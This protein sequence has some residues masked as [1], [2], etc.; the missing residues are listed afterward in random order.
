LLS[1]SFLLTLASNLNA[2]ETAFRYKLYLAGQFLNSAA[3]EETG[4]V[5][6]GLDAAL[7][8]T[9]LDIPAEYSGYKVIGIGASAFLN[10]NLS[11]VVLPDTLISIGSRAFKDNLL[12]EILIP[13]KV[14][15]IG[16]A[17]FAG[18]VLEKAVLG[19]AVV[20]I[21]NDAF[22]R[23]KLAS[24]TLGKSLEVIGYRAFESNYRIASLE[25]PETLVE[26]R[27]GAFNG[28]A[29]EEL[30]IPSSVSVIEENAF[31]YNKLR[32]ITIPASVTTLGEGAFSANSDLNLASFLGDRPSIASDSIFAEGDLQQISYCAGKD[33]WPGSE[34]DGI[35]PSAD[36]DGDGISDSS[37]AFP[38][39]AS[40]SV[41]TDGDD[42]GNNA[43]TDDDNDGVPDVAGWS[44][45]GFDIYGREVGSRI[46]HSV[47][48]SNDG[49]VLAIGAPYRGKVPFNH[50]GVARVHGWNGSVWVERGLG[51]YGDPDVR[52]VGDRNDN[53]GYSVS[54]SGDGSV[55][56]VGAP[57]FL[58]I[59]A[60]GEFGSIG[61]RLRAGSSSVWI[62]MEKQ[63]VTAMVFPFLCQMM[64]R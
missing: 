18:N 26:I 20:T 3:V 5:I 7:S 50:S 29:L 38:L 23:N 40:E 62:L 17:A 52:F 42:I 11:Q 61:A 6:T 9:A 24:I 1:L 28:N 39:D 49:S 59:P 47:S 41:D 21:D 32:R 34:I 63:P 51:F 27:G 8:G 33:G 22:A 64:A 16:L 53:N 14:I 30:I 46:G 10:Y 48:L 4:V 43:D 45:L 31:R 56:A 54:L 25:L 12:T 60:R 37:D 44:Q 55:I 35:L 57:S 2:D 15:Y 19:D 13:D 58:L 36:C